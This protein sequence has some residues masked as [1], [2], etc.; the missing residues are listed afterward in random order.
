MRSGAR[1]QDVAVV[2]TDVTTFGSGVAAALHDELGGD[3]AERGGEHH[4]H[5]RAVRLQVAA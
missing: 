2:P 1:R 4:D 5:L 3:R